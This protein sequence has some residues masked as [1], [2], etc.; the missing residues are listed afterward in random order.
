MENKKSALDENAKR[1]RRI[2]AK[3]R[4]LAKIASD[5][6]VDAFVRRDISKAIFF[7]YRSA[8][9]IKQKTPEGIASELL[10]EAAKQAGV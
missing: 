7:L 1:A 2:L 3:A 8:F 10:R 6:S 5:E 9:G 4:Y